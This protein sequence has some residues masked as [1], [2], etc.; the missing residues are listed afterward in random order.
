MSAPVVFA[1]LAGASGGTVMVN[2]F[3]V[4]A[5]CSTI[6]ETVNVF[7]VGGKLIEVD[8]PLPEVLGALHEAA[9]EVAE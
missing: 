2:P 6:Q 5:L 8:G 9:D 4:A 3:H 1:A 7:L